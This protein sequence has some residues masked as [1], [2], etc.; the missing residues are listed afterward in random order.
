MDKRGISEDELKA[1]LAEKGINLDDLKSMSPEQALQ[2]Q[3][4]IEAAIKEI[5]AE[6]AS[7]NSKGN[8]AANSNKS[9]KVT[10]SKIENAKEN[11]PID[12]KLG[13][14]E[15]DPVL[16][17][18][19]EP[20]VTEPTAIWGQNIFRNKSLALFRQTNDIKP[21]DSYILGI[22]DQVTVAIWG[23]SQLNETYE[24]N[25]DGYIAPDRMPRIFLKGVTI[26]KAK[27]MLK[28]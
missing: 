11:K 4:T 10:N 8:A 22:G 27:P 26:G 15:K 16:E 6:K 24:I 14:V 28:N 21:P 17:E 5:E 25:A 20:V 2:M 3:S 7:S 9:V 23:M 1:K 13:G 19:K 18:G 12:A